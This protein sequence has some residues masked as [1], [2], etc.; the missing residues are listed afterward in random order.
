MLDE[1]VDSSDHEQLAVC[2]WYLDTILVVHEDF[3]GLYHW[4]EIKANNI[5]SIVKKT[6]SYSFCLDAGG[7][8]F[9]GEDHRR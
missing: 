4:T 1:C 7:C 5:E 9:M 8:F 3:I 6:H 2:N